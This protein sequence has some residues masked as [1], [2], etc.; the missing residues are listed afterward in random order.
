MEFHVM[1]GGSDNNEGTRTSPFRTISKAAQI[2]LPG[3][4]VTVHEGVYREWVNPANG[5]TEHSRIVY[6]A[7]EGE[8]VVISG[9]EVVTDWTLEAGTVWKASIPNSLFGDRHPYVEKVEGDWFFERV[10]TF[11]TGEVY[12]DGK[13]MYE[14]QTLDEVKNP[15]ET[16]N[17]FDKPGSLYTWYSE[18]ADE[19]TTI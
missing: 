16:E 12:L 7:A 8:T 10:K 18:V 5:G 2:A 6:Q 9:G 4:V 1:T 13:S 17:T 11:H 14:A 3:D 15:A 19:F